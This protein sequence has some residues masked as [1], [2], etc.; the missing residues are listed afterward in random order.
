MSNHINNRRRFAR[1]KARRNAY[2]PIETTP[3]KTERSATHSGT[4]WCRLRS[5]ALGAEAGGTG[6]QEWKEASHRAWTWKP[7]NQ[8]QFRPPLPYLNVNECRI[9]MSDGRVVTVAF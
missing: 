8:G 6:R 3:D 2:A 5:A 7:M 1:R 9:P 4:I